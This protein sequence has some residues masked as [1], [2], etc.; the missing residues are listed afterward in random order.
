MNLGLVVLPLGPKVYWKAKTALAI[1]AVEAKKIQLLMGY[2]CD[3][4]HDFLCVEE[5]EGMHH[6]TWNTPALP[7]TLKTEAD[8]TMLYGEQHNQT[9]TEANARSE[10]DQTLAGSEHREIGPS[11]KD[12]R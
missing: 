7:L 9:D 6:S 5:P 10:R 12:R 3:V 4:V 11:H 8:K 1:S 2:E